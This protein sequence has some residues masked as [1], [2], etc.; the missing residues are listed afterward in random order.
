MTDSSNLIAVQTRKNKTGTTTAKVSVARERESEI[1]IDNQAESLVKIPIN[2]SSKDGFDSSS[3]E[4]DRTSANFG[5]T[6]NDDDLTQ[7]E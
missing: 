3:H 7:V 5:G 6:Q 2:D 1:I 4:G